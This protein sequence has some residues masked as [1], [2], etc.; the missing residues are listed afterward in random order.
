MNKYWH[1]WKRNNKSNW[2]GC[3][4]RIVVYCSIIQFHSRRPSSRGKWKLCKLQQI[5]ENT[6]ILITF[7]SKY[8]NYSLNLQ[9]VEIK[10]NSTKCYRKCYLKWRSI[11]RNSFNEF[12][13]PSSWKSLN[14]SN[15]TL[16]SLICNSSEQF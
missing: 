14:D 10:R 2:W 16:S 6:F 12:L 15:W 5:W 11:A 9:L 13:S 8:C 4:C 1:F 7:H 3:I